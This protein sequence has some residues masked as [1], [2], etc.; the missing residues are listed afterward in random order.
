M[1]SLI[2]AGRPPNNLHLM[3]RFGVD[4]RTVQ[5]DWHDARAVARTLK[6]YQDI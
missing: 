2:N 1:A 3:W 5:R 4:L 6:K